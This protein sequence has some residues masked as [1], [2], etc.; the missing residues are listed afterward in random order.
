MPVRGH[1]R[2]V[3]GHSRRGI[4]RERYVPAACTRQ[5]TC[6]LGVLEGTLGVSQ[7]TLGV[8]FVGNAT[9][10]PRAPFDVRAQAIHAV[11]VLRIPA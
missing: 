10:L 7:G 4:C 6:S 3:R 11:D 5:G 2:R 1:S 9:C 8:V